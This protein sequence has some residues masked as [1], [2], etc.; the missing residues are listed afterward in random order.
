MFA[1]EQRRYVGM[2]CRGGV[3]TVGEISGTVLFREFALQSRVYGRTI[4][5]FT[6]F[7]RIILRLINPGILI[8]RDSCPAFR[9]P[10]L[11]NESFPSRHR[12]LKFRTAGLLRQ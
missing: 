3:G 10:M 9:F 2:Q 8:E 5:K 11:F 7:P 6:A 1:I 12:D 4:R